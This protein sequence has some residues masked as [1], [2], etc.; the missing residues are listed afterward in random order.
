MKNFAKDSLL[1]VQPAETRELDETP[2][3]KR[4]VKSLK[5]KVAIIT[6]GDSGIGQAVAL[7]YAEAGIRC[8]IVHYGEP[9]D[10]EYVVQ[11]V[12]E[13]GSDALALE[14]DL[15]SPEFCQ[16]VVTR[17]LGAYGSLDILVNNAGVQYPQ[18]HVRDILPEQLEQTF[19]V[20]VFSMFYL[21]QAALPHLHAG[22]T[23]INTASVTAFRGSEHLVD[24]AA[25]KGA[26]V[27]FTRSLALQLAEE[28]IRVNA[29]APGPI[30]TPLIPG[31]FSAEHVHTFGQDTLMGRKGQPFE[32]A[33]CYLFL[34]L[35]EN[36]YMT[37]QVLHPNGGD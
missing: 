20:N 22:S 9:E 32:V 27:A 15:R 4:P 26:I 11:Q 6:G 33:P 21:T 28:G 2:E 7:C 12:K 1:P 23:I 19:A 13:L 35:E 29:V 25:T 14:G 37:G 5:G 17:T 16:E 3:T 10:A 36:S 8:V 24:Y 34:A 18:A 31:S 30:W